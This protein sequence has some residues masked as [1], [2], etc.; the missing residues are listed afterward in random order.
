MTNW[1]GYGTKQLWP[2]LSYYVST[3]L[4]WSRVLTEILRRGDRPM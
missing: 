1:K 4:E 3:C 2:V